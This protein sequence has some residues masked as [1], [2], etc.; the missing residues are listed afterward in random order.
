MMAYEACPDILDPLFPDWSDK[1]AIELYY[2][3][4]VI[5]DGLG[6]YIIKPGD[7]DYED[8]TSPSTTSLSYA[9]SPTTSCPTTT[10]R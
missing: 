5:Q 9:S 10:S 8:P 4:K 6:D 2:Q 1:A 3:E 7:P